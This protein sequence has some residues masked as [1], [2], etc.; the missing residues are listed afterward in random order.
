MTQASAGYRDQVTEVKAELTAL[1]S[2]LLNSDV[3]T[4]GHAKPCQAQVDKAYR[5]QVTEVKAE[6][7]GIHAGF[8]LERTKSVAMK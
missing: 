5:D 1:E 8:Q 6:L 7:T 4:D 3:P 2:S